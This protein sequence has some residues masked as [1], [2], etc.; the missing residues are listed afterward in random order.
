MSELGMR[1]LFAF[2]LLCFLLACSE[3]QTNKDEYEWILTADPES[4][5]ISAA[6]SGDRTLI[7]LSGLFVNVIPDVTGSPCKKPKDVRYFRID[8]VI[9]SYA[10]TKFN[11]LAP[12]YA[13]HY[14]YY[15]RKYFDAK[16]QDICN[17]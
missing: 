2:V 14:N 5:A 13:E 7:G 6:R 16:G 10:E 15:L 12:V 11:A 17:S 3:S 1:I 9:D 4:D 8:D